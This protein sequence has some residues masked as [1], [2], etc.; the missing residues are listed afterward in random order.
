MPGSNA[1]D[2]ACLDQA[3]RYTSSE[4]THYAT[5]DET[6][7]MKIDNLRYNFCHYRL[8]NINRYQLT[9]AIDWISD[10]ID[11]S[12]QGNSTNK[13]V[14]SFMW[15]MEKFLITGAGNSYNPIPFKYNNSFQS[16]RN[17]DRRLADF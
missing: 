8:S 3:F 7:S 16:Y 14:Y 1:R 6:Q 9:H 10:F 4:K 2:A 11:L 5:I 13:I 15:S 12:R 17:I